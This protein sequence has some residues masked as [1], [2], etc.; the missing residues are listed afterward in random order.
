MPSAVDERS[1]SGLFEF[2]FR[3][4]RFSGLSQK[5]GTSDSFR[6]PQGFKIDETG[7]Q[8]YLPGIGFVKYRRS[9]YI[10]GK[11]K[12]VTVMRKADGWYV[13]IQTEYEKEIPKHNGDE[14]GMDMGGAPVR[15][16]M[17]SWVK[18]PT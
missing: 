15:R 14:V 6:Y 12:N 4:C 5:F 8:I 13:S 1:L 9:R 7:K 2:L 11:A 10:E 18:V 16:L 3:S 17:H